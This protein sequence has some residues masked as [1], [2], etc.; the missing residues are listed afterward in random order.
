MAQFRI[1]DQPR[2]ESAPQL[3]K[4][5]KVHSRKAAE[6]SFDR[7]TRKD[8]ITGFRKR[9]LERQKKGKEL[10][11]EKDKASRR[12]LKKSRDKRL[13]GD[14]AGAWDKEAEA[15]AEKQKSLAASETAE[16]EVL[17]F[18]EGASASVV[19][20]EP[21]ADNDDSFGISENKLDGLGSADILKGIGKRG[22]TAGIS[23]IVTSKAK[24]DMWKP[25]KANGLAQ[26][27]KKRDAFGDDLEREEA[28]K[29]GEE[30]PEWKLHTRAHRPPPSM[31]R[32][33]KQQ[34][35]Q[36]QSIKLKSTAY[37]KEKRLIKRTGGG[38]YSKGLVM[39]HGTRANQA[40]HKGKGRAVG[41]GS[42]GSSRGA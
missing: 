29:D 1:A 30:V 35:F 3:P 12:A 28:G 13:F 2:V 34:W 15:E 33:N 17:Q 18:G 36:R 6:A 32:Q 21:W 23:M 7:G 8:Y 26:G 11:V 19:S 24:R 42:K 38:S 27:Y 4:K 39:K 31:S 37:K 25:N 5:V 20:I 10:L 14:L 22:S 41:K 16:A 9:R 40:R